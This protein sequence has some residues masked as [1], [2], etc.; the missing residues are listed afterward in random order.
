M[1]WLYFPPT[2]VEQGVVG[3]VILE[4]RIQLDTRANCEIGS[5]SPEG[6]GFG[7]AARALSRLFRL[8]PATR[9][10]EP[11]AGANLRVPIN[12]LFPDGAGSLPDVASLR[13]GGETFPLSSPNLPIWEAAPNFF[14]VL[15]AYPRQAARDRVRG[16]GVLRCIVRQDRS[17][18]CQLFRETPPGY[19]FGEAAMQLA[20]QF[21][22]SERE[23]EFV[24]AHQTAPFF[25]PVNF[26]ARSELEPLNRM[27]DGLAPFVLPPID[28][29]TDFYPPAA[30]AAGIAGEVVI[31]CT[32][33]TER[34]FECVSE[35]ETPMGWGLAAAVVER[36]ESSEPNVD[37]F[38]ILP[39]DQVRTTVRFHRE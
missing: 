1:L 10:G 38:G 3:R 18:N 30:L 16:R 8:T 12:F 24:A 13:V 33:S 17:L 20:L 22:V 34:Q 11:V 6:W 5:E 28:A 9:G 29:P 32:W 25:L 36:F 26:G 31:L 19:G 7:D 35:R 39:G 15:D 2:A 37:Y 14:A 27:Y 21:R 23:Q 4:C